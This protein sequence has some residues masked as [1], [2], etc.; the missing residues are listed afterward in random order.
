VQHGKVIK[1]FGWVDSD[2]LAID[3]GPILLGIANY[4][5]QFIWNI[6]RDNAVLRRGL[7]KA[8]FKGGYLDAK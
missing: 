8:G 6:L 2:Y 7:V 3:Q 1:G 5:N 4:R